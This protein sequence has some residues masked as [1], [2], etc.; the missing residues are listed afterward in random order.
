MTKSLKTA[1]RTAFL[2]IAASAGLVACGGGGGGGASTPTPGAALTGTLRVGL[3]DAPACGFREVNVTVERVRFHMS[4][5]AGDNDAGWTDIVVSPGPRTINLLDLMNGV[6]ADLGQV[7]LPAGRYTQVRLV[8]VSNRNTVLP[9]G[10]SMKSLDTPS[11]TQSGL[12]LTH[13]FTVE[14]DQLTDLVIDFDACRSIV[15]RGNGTYGLKP[16]LSVIPA[17]GA[18]IQGYVQPG[19][20]GVTVSAQKDGVVLRATQPNAE[21]LF[22]LAPVDPTKTPYDIVFTAADR[23]TS[24]VTN[25]P[26]AANTTTNVGTSAAAI[27]MATSASGIASGTVVLNGSAATPSVRAVQQVTPAVKV[28]VAHINA[29]VAGEYSLSLPVEAPLLATFAS[30]LPPAPFAPQAGAAAKYRLEASATGYTA[31]LGDE[32]TVVDG[33]PNTGQDFTLAPA[34]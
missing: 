28:E 34:P 10:D 18:V 8:L 15:Q 17:T 5:A 14:P 23:K 26:A 2:A 4:S 12:K 22:V 16:V 29:N 9:E 13:A 6:V 31:K 32:I 27:P 24:V 11:G 3:T 21:G 33:T 7:T 30:P 25:V 20:A 1:V 19:V